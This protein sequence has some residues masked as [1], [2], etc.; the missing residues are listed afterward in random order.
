MAQL[1]AGEPGF[2]L[3]VRPYQEHSRLIEAFTLNYGRV[4]LIARISAKGSR[5]QALLQPFCP[6]QLSML[7]GR[8][9]IWRLTECNRSGEPFPL[10]V[11]QLFSGYYLNELIYYLLKRGDS[12]PQLFACYLATLRSLSDGGAEE[13]ALR[14]FELK[15]LQH[16][17]QGLDF[18]A[19]DG[20]SFKAQQYYCYL[21][22]QGFV[23][24]L[25][26]QM[27]S[28]AGQTLNALAQGLPQ[29]PQLLQVLKQVTRTCIAM[30][31]QGRE[32]K[33]RQMYQQYLQL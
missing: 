18:H 32:L 10:P 22:G 29:E 9:E 1:H 4:C 14:V 3:H 11:P 2:I 28:F 6:L 24:Q 19:P 33:S 30:L 21:P 23:P 12:A 8:S 13:Q 25:D 31:L 5:Q 26:P 17:G 15:L 20:K 27:P 7:Q 16:L